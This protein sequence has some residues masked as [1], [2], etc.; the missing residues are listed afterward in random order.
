M[1]SSTLD[2]D[3]HIC[4]VMQQCNVM[5]FLDKHS[6]PYEKGVPCA[7]L[8]HM[9]KTV[10]NGICMLRHALNMKNY[11]PYVI[12]TNT[13]QYLLFYTVKPIL[14]HIQ[15]TVQFVRHLRADALTS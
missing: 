2:H 1:Q 12:S 4:N 15:D 7:V 6:T 5:P 11:Q 13:N 10:A 8:R 3:L 14:N 9:R